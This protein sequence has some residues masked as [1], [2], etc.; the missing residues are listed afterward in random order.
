V[1]PGGGAR[2]AAPTAVCMVQGGPQGGEQR[3]TA[4]PPLPHV[5]ECLP[6]CLPALLCSAALR[7]AWHLAAFLQLGTLRLLSA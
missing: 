5:P 1:T 6:A 4:R 3:V 7:A 2:A